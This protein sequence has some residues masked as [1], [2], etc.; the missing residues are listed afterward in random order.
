MSRFSGMM[1]GP[2][3]TP[4]LGGIGAGGLSTTGGGGGMMKALGTFLNN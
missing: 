2:K 1:G 3:G 4:A